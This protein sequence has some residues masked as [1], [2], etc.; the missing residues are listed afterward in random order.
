MNNLKEMEDEVSTWP[1]R[2]TRTALAE[3]NSDSG[4]QR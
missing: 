2:F 1:S 4:A 3:E